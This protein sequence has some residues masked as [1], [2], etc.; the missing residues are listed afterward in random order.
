MTEERHLQAV[1]A[2]AQGADW[3]AAWVDALNELEL[4]VDQAEALLRSESPELPAPVAWV[5]PA[6]PPIPP[7]LVERARLVHARQLDLAAR[8]TRRMG[9]LGRQ[10]TLAGRIETG[11][12][13]RARP[14]LL[15][16]AC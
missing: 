12:A 5:P 16:Q 6:L 8:M 1:E 2:A 11:A 15:D 7:D 9:D 10:A 13:G 14:V 4:Q 3:S